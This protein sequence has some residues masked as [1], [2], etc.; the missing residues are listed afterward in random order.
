MEKM[1]V[2]IGS[3]MVR[4]GRKM[5]MMEDTS[6]PTDA[7]RSPNTCKLA[8]LRL[9]LDSYIKKRKRV[10]WHPSAF[11]NPERVLFSDKKTHMLSRALGSTFFLT[12]VVFVI[13]VSIFV[14]MQVSMIMFMASVTMSM[15]T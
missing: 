13:V 6:T 4:S 12:K 8:A 9:I 2:Q 1:N 5:R 15:S 11:V 3:T 10:G 7:R 14:G